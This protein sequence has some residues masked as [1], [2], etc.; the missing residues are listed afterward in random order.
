MYNGNAMK[1][2]IALIFPFLLA[3]CSVMGTYANSEKYLIGSQEYEGEL[4]TLNINW[5]AGTLTLV[6]DENAT[7]I[8]VSEENSLSDAEKVYSY[9]HDNTL[10]VQ[11]CASGFVGHI[12]SNQKNLTITYKPGIEKLNVSLTSGTFKADAL[13]TSEINLSLTSG[14]VE[15]DN[16]EASVINCS[17]TSGSITFSNVKTNKFNSSFTSGSATV[18][19]EELNEAKLDGTSGYIVLRTPEVGATVHVSQTSGKT[20][21]HREGTVSNG[22]YTYGDGSAKVSISLTSGTVE[23]Y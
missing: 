16:V 3:S 1:K 13:H 14:K 20:N 5:V 15:I 7:S 19:F 21:S 22:T 8:K 18:N 4:T 9:F 23:L 17:S 2:L 6:E 10:D 11:Y 12:D